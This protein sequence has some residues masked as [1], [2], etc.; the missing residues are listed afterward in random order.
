MTENI[1]N[2]QTD[3]P[4]QTA[5]KK[6]EIEK[7]ERWL[8]LIS[9]AAAVLADRLLFNT[10]AER[11]FNLFFFAAVFESCFIVL[12][13][14]FNWK[15]IYNKCLV[16]LFSSFII[17]LCIWNF[18]FDYHSYY[19]MLTFIVTPAALMMFIQFST[20]QYK[21]KQV[22]G[23][24]K[25]WFGGWFIQ[26]FSALPRFISVVSDT[27]FPKKNPLIKKIIVAVAVTLPLAAVLIVLLSGA[28]KVFGHY[29]SIIFKNFDLGSF[30]GHLLL[31]AVLLAL[32]YSFFWNSR[33]AQ[34]KPTSEPKEI[35]FDA[36]ISYVALGT[37]LALYTLFCAIQFTY[38]FA[39]AGLPSGISY[40][41]YAREG[42]AQI[43]AIAAINLLIFGVVLKYG[44]KNIGVM[45]MLYGLLGV[46]AIMLVSGFMRLSL[47]IDT[48]GMTFLRLISAWFM[49]YLALVLVFCVLRLLKD[50]VP[51]VAICA[52]LLLGWYIVLGYINPDAFILKYNLS[53]NGDSAAWVSDNIN[54]IKYELSDDAILILAEKDLYKED[55]R[56]LFADRYDL[57]MKKYNAAS[58]KL[59]NRI[60]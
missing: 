44:R 11:L 37:S 19:G 34:A 10:S 8:I 36:V 25:A 29:V 45:I 38:L 12:Y 16:W 4:V 30:V 32:F 56:E 23:I 50:K 48:F 40:S 54:Y 3:E 59:R 47:Y 53:A 15:R 7:L 33:Y 6:I 52:F 27:L 39:R 20:N 46:T 17:L 60:Q 58:T 26:P 49:I 51:L 43:V 13:Y 24:I 35:S 18:L 1:N 31:T 28:D 42:F 14:I 57:A 9:F 41:E 5:D 2:I 21:L 22:S 55:Y